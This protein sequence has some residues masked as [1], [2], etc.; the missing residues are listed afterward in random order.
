MNALR[1]LGRA[2]DGWWRPEVPAE[3]LAAF[4]ILVGLYGVVYLIIR[5]PFLMSYGRR[6]PVEWEPVGLATWLADPLPAWIG[7]TQPLLLPPLALAFT[8]GIAYRVVA[9][10]YAALLLWV[11]TYS[12]SWGFILHT[13]NML[14]LHTLVLAAAPMAAD[15]WSVDARRRPPEP[16][17]GAGCVG[18]RYGWPLMLAATACVLAYFLAGVAKIRH[19]GA[20]FF[21]G[22]NLRNYVAYDLVR[23]TELGSISTPIGEWLVSFPA[24]FGVLA[25]ISL[26]TEL[27]APLA[28]LE[29]RIGK[30]WALTAWG[31]HWGVLVVMAITFAYQMTAIAFAP[32]FRPE[33]LVRRFPFVRGADDD[34]DDAPGGESSAAAAV[35]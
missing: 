19:G 12:N 16:G 13:D 34:A 33:R 28:V 3:R 6:N 32:F 17:R 11:M 29:R 7:L 4:R 31:F 8:V 24:L 27:L 20:A 25:W 18:G 23:K 9:P 14:T 22:E 2:I 30:V 5:T 1:R 21:G 15:A 10:L 35:P 26:G